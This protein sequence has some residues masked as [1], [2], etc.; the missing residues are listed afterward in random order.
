MIGVIFFP[1]PG[2]RIATVA[3]AFTWLGGMG[4]T[5]GYHRS[6]AH[7]SVRF[8]PI[9]RHALIFFA[10][11]NGS[12]APDSWTA[13]HRQH[14]SKVETPDDISSPSVGGFWWAHLRWLWQAGNAPLSR[15]SPDLDKREY[16]FWNR[17]QVPILALSLFGPL[18]FGLTAFFWV[19]ALRLVFSLHVQCFVNSIAHMRPH[20]APGE[21]SSQN[22]TWLGV[23]HLFQG[24]NWHGN[25]HAKPWSARLGW[26][27]W[28]IDC[29]WYAIVLLEW[30]GLAAKVRRPQ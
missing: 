7:V 10:M 11:F 25:H 30:M 16:R 3:L 2:W 22:I 8:H 14:H 28:Q 24:E 18:A 15:W 23:L 6:L 1:V 9:V 27:R 13:N 12:G 5:I 4:V 21:D 17:V 20:R 19:G 29:G 26:T